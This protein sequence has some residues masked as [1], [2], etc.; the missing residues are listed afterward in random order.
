MANTSGPQSSIGNGQTLNTDAARYWLALV[1][2]IAREHKITI[3]PTEGTRV[4]ARQKYLY[5]GYRAGRIDPSTGRRFN[6]AWSPDDRRAYHLSGRAVD[7]GSSVGYVTTLASQVFYS[8][9]GQYGFRPTVQGEPWHFEWSATWVGISLEVAAT[10]KQTIPATPSEEDDML[11]PRFI[12]V[13]QEGHPLH[14]LVAFAFE[15]RVIRTNGEDE[16]Y[17]L[18]RFWGLVGPNQPW[19]ESKH[20][21]VIS[22]AEYAA[23]ETEINKARTTTRLEHA[24]TT[25][26]TV[27]GFM[28]DGY[29]KAQTAAARLAGIDEK[30]GK[31]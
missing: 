20:L 4:Y 14:N 2:R 12:Q 30:A 15:G 5:D 21:E 11:K 17:R 24:K 18:G 8:L 23:G 10:V 1:E 28:I 3:V 13:K 25:A 29:N 6:P 7:V 19:R 26:E 9:A 31:K 16:V 27:W 22:P